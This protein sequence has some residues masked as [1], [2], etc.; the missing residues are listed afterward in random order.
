MN[1]RD[2]LAERIEANRTHLVALQ[3]CRPQAAQL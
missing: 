1:E 2:H 3:R